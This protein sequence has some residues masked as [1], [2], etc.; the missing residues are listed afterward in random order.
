M[1]HRNSGSL[2]TRLRRKAGNAL[3]AIAA[4]SAIGGMALLI[5]LAVFAIPLAI[6][7]SV[8]MYTSKCMC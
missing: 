1:K 7:L 2:A 8:W 6:I 4:F 3:A 5:L